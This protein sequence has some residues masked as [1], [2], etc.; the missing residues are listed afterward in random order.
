MV[1]IWKQAREVVIM[2]ESKLTG[3]LI[4]AGDEATKSDI[5]LG[6]M[7]TLLRSRL[8]QMLHE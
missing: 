8:S 3:P 6:L 7:R 1:G 5:T 2:S 4:L